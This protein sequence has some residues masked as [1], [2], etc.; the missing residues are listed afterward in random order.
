MQFSDGDKY[1]LVPS[2]D[3]GLFICNVSDGKV[4]YSCLYSNGLGLCFNKNL[5]IVP[6]YLASYVGAL[7]PPMFQT[8]IADD[9]KQKPLL[10]PNPGTGLV[11]IPIDWACEQ[12]STVVL[13]DI[14]GSTVTVPCQCQAGML[15]FDV[16]NVSSG[17]RFLLDRSFSVLPVV[18]GSLRQSS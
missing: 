7:A 13:C 16:S 12:N 6:S 15:C 9:P 3:S 5:S 2:M 17:Q 10:Y 4:I 8:G 14:L 1:V 18:P 11:K